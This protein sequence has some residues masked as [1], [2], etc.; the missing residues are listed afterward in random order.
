MVRGDKFMNKYK[1]HLIT[2]VISIA[3]PLLFFS[4]TSASAATLTSYNNLS[5]FTNIKASGLTVS[6]IGSRIL[7]QYISDNWI[8]SPIQENVP[9]DKIWT[10]N[11][12]SPASKESIN[13]SSVFV[14]DNEKRKI[15]TNLTLSDDGK[16][17]KISPITNYTPDHGYLL[18][19]IEPSGGTC[20]PFTID[21]DSVKV[22]KSFNNKSITLKKGQAL[23]LT[24]PDIGFDGGYAWKLNSLNNSILNNT[25]SFKIPTSYYPGGYPGESLDTR[26]LFKAVNT[27]TTSLNLEYQQ[28]WNGS[29]SNIRTF[30]LTI[31]VQ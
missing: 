10:I 27:G 7:S 17:V 8:S 16:Q 26:W 29:A 6:P 2:I 9:K 31:N 30:N 25:D 20:I 14:L 12:K 13:S 1:I 23:Q 24:L 3:S 11:L 18:I 5:N 28:Y 22:N 4:T 15:E 21:S 19:V